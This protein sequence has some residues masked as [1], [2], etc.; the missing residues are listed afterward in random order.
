MCSREILARRVNALARFRG[1]ESE[2]MR[3][4]GLIDAVVAVRFGGYGESFF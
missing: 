3:G 2:R 1:S 4:E